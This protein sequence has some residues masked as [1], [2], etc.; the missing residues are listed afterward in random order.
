MLKSLGVAIK[1]SL[2]GIRGNIDARQAFQLF[3]DP[4]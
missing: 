4:Y 1:K 3:K 2:T